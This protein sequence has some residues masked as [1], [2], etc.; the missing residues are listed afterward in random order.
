MSLAAATALPQR[1]ALPRAR[2]SK[3]MIIICIPSLP[4]CPAAGAPGRRRGHAAVQHGGRAH[5]LLESRDQ[6]GPSRRSPAVAA[7]PLHTWAPASST[8]WSAHEWRGFRH[9]CRHWTC[10]GAR[11]TVTFSLTWTSRRRCLTV[12]LSCMHSTDQRWQP[13]RW[14]PLAADHCTPVAD[15]SPQVKIWGLDCCACRRSSCCAH[16]TDLRAETAAAILRISNLSALVPQAVTIMQ[17][18][19]WAA[20]AAMPQQQC[21]QQIAWRGGRPAMRSSWSGPGTSGPTSPCSSPAAPP[22]APAG[23]FCSSK[24]P[25]LPRSG[26][27]NGIMSL[28]R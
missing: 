11:P 17:V 6:G 1:E 4:F 8:N 18:P 7:P 16:H 28:K 19:A 13:P 26:A 12:R 15:C 21:G 3:G 24:H 22:T 9:T 5:R 14:C 10:S 25:R 20:A 23:N 2:Q 27:F